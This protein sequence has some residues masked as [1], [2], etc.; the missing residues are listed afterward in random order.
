VEDD[1]V[2]VMKTVAARLRLVVVPM[3]NALLL[4]KLEVHRRAMVATDSDR[5]M[6]GGRF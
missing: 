2:A 5:R 6:V 3:V 4:L 1:S